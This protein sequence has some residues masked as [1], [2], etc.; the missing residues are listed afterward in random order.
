MSP[1]STLG[2]HRQAAPSRFHATRL[3]DCL[4]WQATDRTTSKRINRLLEAVLRDLLTGIGK[5]EQSKHVLQGGWS[6]S[7]DEE[8]LLVYPVEGDDS[9]ILQPGI[10]TSTEVPGQAPLTPARAQVGAAR[11][12][13]THRHRAGLLS[14]FVQEAWATLCRASALKT[15]RCTGWSSFQ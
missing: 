5:P 13:P 10:A 8:H 12:R 1:R 7:T 15:R 6:R 4:Y 9:V 14:G 11:P 3:E 2:P